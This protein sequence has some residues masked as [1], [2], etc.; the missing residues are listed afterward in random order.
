MPKAA[1][2]RRFDLSRTF[3]PSNVRLGLVWNL[4]QLKDLPDRP[5]LRLLEP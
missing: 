2:Q 3:G 4:N 5:E 1:E